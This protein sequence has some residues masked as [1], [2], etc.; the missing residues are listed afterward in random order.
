[1]RSGEMRQGLVR[2]CEVLPTILPTNLPTYLPIYLHRTHTLLFHH[3]LAYLFW[4]PLYSFLSELKPY[5]APFWYTVNS[6]LVRTEVSFGSFVCPFRS[7][8]VSSGPFR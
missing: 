8:P 7:V 5:S 3:Y 2:E 1:M 4:Y 6:V